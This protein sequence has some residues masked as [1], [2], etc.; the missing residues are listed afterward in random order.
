V[1]N[2]PIAIRNFVGGRIYSL[3]SREEPYIRATLAKLRRG[4]GKHPG[5]LPDIWDFT[6]ENLPEVFLSRSGVPT[7]G[8]WAV[9]ISLTLFAL[10][11]QGRDPKLNPMS[12]PILEGGKTIGNAVQALA[13]KR[14]TESK[15]AIKRRFD[16]IITSNSSEE[17]AFH[18]RG[19]INLIKSESIPIDYPLLAE[20]IFRFQSEEQRD[21]VR[22]K[23]GQDYYFYQGKDENDDEK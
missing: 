19:M 20:D 10:H 21:N 23:W 7:S 17:L 5:K 9:H 14:G 2:R 8:E 15:E 1:E 11:Q 18:L 3:L 12:K 6:L 16:T 22:L 4:L 13:I